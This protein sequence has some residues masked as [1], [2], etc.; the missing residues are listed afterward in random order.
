MMNRL[1]Q[2]LAE[3]KKKKQKALALF[4]TAGDPSLK[5][6]EQVVRFCDR[7]GVDLIEIGVPFS[8]P[9]ADGPVIQASAFRALEKGVHLK[10]ILGL[11]RRLRGEG[12]QIPIVLMSSANPLY[13]TG[14]VSVARDLSEAGVDGVI[15]P[16]LPLEESA[17]LRRAFERRDLVNIMMTTPTTEGRRRRDILRSSRGF[18]YFVA[19]IGLTGDRHESAAI[20]SRR[21]REARL[22]A[23]SPVLAGFGISGPADARAMC[24]AADGV[25]VGSA[26]VQHLHQ[27]SPRNLSDRSRKFILSL[28]KA[29]K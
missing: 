28:L 8:D 17:E 7:S 15:I 3:L 16:D 22:T 4:V 27:H 18:V 1:E 2:R 9:I 29:V 12:L 14:W 11:V 19:L 25:I 24:S 5:V 20:I 13:G 6:T 26:L 10:Q 23:T 21:I